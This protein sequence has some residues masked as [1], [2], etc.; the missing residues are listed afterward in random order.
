M[1]KLLQL[2]KANLV[3]LVNAGSLVGTT[4]VTSVLGFAYW[5]LAT[6]LFPPEAVGLA[7]AAISA[8]MLLG[9]VCMLGLGTL[10]TGELPRQLG[11]EGPLISAALIIT[12]GVGGVLGIMFAVVAP[13]ISSDFQPLR[14]SGTDIGLFAIGVS[15]TAI[16]LVLDQAL[17]GLLRGGLQ[18]WRNTLFAMAKLVVLFV[19]GYV[20]SF[21]T[22]MTIY[23]TWL[24]GNA[25]SL[26]ALV[27]FIPLRERGV[28]NTY[29][30]QWGLLQKL[31][32]AAIQHHILNLILLAPPLVLPILVTIQLS[33]TENA[34]F[35][36]SFM[37]ANFL[38]GLT[39]ALSTVLYAVS[40]AQPSVLAHKARVTLG[41][42]IAT[43]ILANCVLQFGARQVLGLFGHIYAEQATW[44]LR[45]LS[46]AVFPLIIKSHYI[47]IYR[48]YNRIA[49]AILPIAIGTFAEV[50][51]AAL[52]GYLA[53][54]SGL[55]LGW[56]MALSVEALFMSRAVYRATRPMKALASSSQ[57][58][59]STFYHDGTSITETSTN[60]SILE[61]RNYSTKKLFF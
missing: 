29:L 12:G 21:V 38:F 7:S 51:G 31:G 55:S 33:A 61:R 8:M 23:I 6:Q 50:G 20:L 11:K 35:Y 1:R 30:P 26:V 9:T 2:A 44:S 19:A 22:G 45:I 56:L 57:L 40:S 3:M 46:L 4:A 24:I 16:T 48:V 59:L 60:E 34:W 47:A 27:G 10:L 32:S 25:L 53:G 39:Y 18:L 28:R 52:G 49:Y 17:I 37:L 15:L 36:V 42:A 41:L 14:A 58:E 13:L 43:S 54:L 5:W